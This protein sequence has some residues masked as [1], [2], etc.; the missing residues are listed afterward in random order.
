MKLLVKIPKI[1]QDE[2]H[3]EELPMIR[4]D[5]LETEK[6]DMAVTRGN[7][8]DSGRTREVGKW[9]DK[10][11]QVGNT[12]Y[13]PCLGFPLLDLKTHLNPQHWNMGSSVLC[14]PIIKFAKKETVINGWQLPSDVQGWRIME[15]L[16][17]N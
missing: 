15:V 3:K 12:G 7:L 11:P 4:L 13:L 5:W 8:G 2:P 9:C 1:V 14:L 10:K 16:C 6:Q 17:Q